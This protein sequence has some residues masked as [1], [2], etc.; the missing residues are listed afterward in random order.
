MCA[1]PNPIQGAVDGAVGH[2]EISVPIDVDDTQP[3]NTMP[4]PGHRADTNCAVASEHQNRVLGC[5]SSDQRSDLASAVDDRTGVRCPGVV[6]VRPPAI[7]GHLSGAVHRHTCRLEQ[8]DQASLEQRVRTILLTRSVA[9][10]ARRGLYERN[11]PHQ[12][13]IP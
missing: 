9:T 3:L 2:V 5:S 6:G 4:Q 13:I 8:V 11:R 7:G 1:T 10:G 12:H